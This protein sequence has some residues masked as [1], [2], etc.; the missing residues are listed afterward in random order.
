MSLYQLTA[1]A[2]LDLIKSGKTS[3]KEAY[4]DVLGRI[5]AVD[6]KV[7]AYVRMASHQPDSIRENAGSHCY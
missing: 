6:G 5:K 3:P 7:K 4:A 2:L 1:H